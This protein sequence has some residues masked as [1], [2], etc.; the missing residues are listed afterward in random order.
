METG[1]AL[2]RGAARA[3]WAALLLLVAGCSSDS[4]PTA[5]AAPGITPLPIAHAWPHE[6]GRTHTYRLV[7]RYGALLAEHRYATAAEV[8]A[9]TLEDVA[10]LLATQAPLAA[11]D[12]VIAGYVTTFNDSATTAMGVRGQRLEMGFTAYPPAPRGRA[13]EFAFAG[14]GGIVEPPVFLTGGIWRA[15]GDTLARFDDLSVA[16]TWMFLEGDLADRGAWEA[17]VLPGVSNQVVMRARAWQSVEVDIAGLRR[18]DALDVHYLLDHGIEVLSVAGG[19]V[20]Y[21]RRFS[22]GRI[23]WGRDAGPMYL[24]ER[25]GLTSG[26]PVL[27]GS[28]ETTLLL[29]STD[30]A[31]RPL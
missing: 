17:R 12:E 5:P 7:T 18:D 24:Y 16:P 13:R 31:P 9:V 21:R 28:V 23:I 8:P 29:E 30:V 25:R 10:D 15:D 2:A 1:I 3:P 27:P 19:G 6:E 4:A 26:T 14:P 11:I 20:E 22:Y